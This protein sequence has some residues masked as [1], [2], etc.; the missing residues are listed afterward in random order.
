M[1]SLH[2]LDETVSV[3]PVSD[4]TLCSSSFRQDVMLVNVAGFNLV[5]AFCIFSS[6]AVV[7]FSTSSRVPGWKYQYPEC[8]GGQVHNQILC[9]NFW[10][11]LCQCESSD[12]VLSTLHHNMLHGL[13]IN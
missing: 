2:H 10:T 5:S 1:W 11:V 9:T 3:Y 12:D 4:R 7:V 13:K 8:S 6:V